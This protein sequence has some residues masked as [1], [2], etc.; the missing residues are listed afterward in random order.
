MYKHSL[1][2][3]HMLAILALLPATERQAVQFEQ[4]ACR[5]LLG[6]YFQSSSELNDPGSHQLGVYGMR[7]LFDGDRYTGWSEGVDGGGVGEVL[8]LQVPKGADTLAVINGFA[9]SLNLFQKNNRVQELQV[10]LRYALL[11]EAMLSELGPV[12]LSSPTG[13]STRLRLKDSAQLEVYT[14]NFDWDEVA[15]GY[16]RVLAAYPDFADREGLPPYLQERTYLLRLEIRDVYP[17][18]AWDDTCLTELRVFNAGALAAAEVY[19][20][21][22]QLWYTIGKE[23]GEGNERNDSDSRRLIYQ[24][25][26]VAFEPVELGP[27][28]RWLTTIRTPLE[29][30][31][32]VATDF[33][34]FKLPYPAPVELAAFTRTVS[35]GG[36]PIGFDYRAGKTLLLMDDGSEIELGADILP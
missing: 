9:R 6:Y 17:G 5:G 10:E 4:L 32:R 33:R 15:A 12:Y 1:V 19:S 7:T 24:E 26:G 29:D 13:A 25:R 2:L 28:G 36:I 14:L 18:T 16:E 22:G 34:L 31:G 23:G 20:R 3:F 35:A 11:P 30:E 27:R 8:W 21:D